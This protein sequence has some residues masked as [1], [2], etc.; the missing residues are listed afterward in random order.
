MKS[1]YEVLG[2]VRGFDGKIRT[3]IMYEMNIDIDDCMVVNNNEK[4]AQNLIRLADQYYGD[5]SL[6]FIIAKANKVSTPFNFTKEKIYIPRDP[7][8]ILDSIK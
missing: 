8:K 1:R 4:K 3:R 2:F 7:F 6:W 5:P